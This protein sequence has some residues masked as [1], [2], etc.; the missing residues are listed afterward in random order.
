MSEG[1]ESEGNYESLGITRT[2]KQSQ[3]GQCPNESIEERYEYNKWL[4]F[5]WKVIWRG[6]NGGSGNISNIAS[7]SESQADEKIVHSPS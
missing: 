1:N 7:E 4:T 2:T 5:I 6:R 3:Y